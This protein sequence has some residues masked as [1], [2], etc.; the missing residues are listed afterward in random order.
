MP[1]SIVLRWK[2]VRYKIPAQCF[3]P[4]TFESPENLTLLN[5]KGFLKLIF[6]NAFEVLSNL[7]TKMTTSSTTTLLASS[8]T[9]PTITPQTTTLSDRTSTKTSSQIIT[10]N[11]TP[12]LTVAGRT[13]TPSNKKVLNLN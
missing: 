8:T 2:K 3:T 9:M 11:I 10:T 5:C 6:S 1:I 12:K 4:F 13:T 7:T